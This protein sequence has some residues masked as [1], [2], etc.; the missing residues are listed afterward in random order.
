MRKRVFVCLCLGLFAVVSAASSSARADGFPDLLAK[1]F[2]KIFGAPDTGPRP[3]HTLKAPF[4]D[5]VDAPLP[6]GELGSLYNDKGVTDGSVGEGMQSPHRHPSQISDWLMQVMSQILNIELAHNED[7]LKVVAATMNPKAQSDF[8]TF[9]TGSNIM[10]TMQARNMNLHSMVENPPIL[11]NKGV[12]GDR[13]R[14]LFEMPV[15]I[16]FLPA[17]STSYD[18]KKG[19]FTS[20][21]II[22]TAQVGRVPVGQGVDELMLESFSVRQNQQ[23][24]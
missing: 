24:P 10:A 16:T 12:V 13:Y 17:G 19:E 14:W 3:E 11:L 20:Q 21:R 23:Q 2:P 18:P 9:M 8:G 15:T 7:Y 4:A 5:S 22:V 1:W 6:D